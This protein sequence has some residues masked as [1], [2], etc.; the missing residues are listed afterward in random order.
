MTRA[1]N[2]LA[3][4]VSTDPLFFAYRITRYQEARRLGD[5]D[6]AQLL[7]CEVAMLSNLRLCHAPRDDKGLTQI[8]TRFKC[9]PHVLAE[10]AFG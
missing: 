6:L 4:R 5:A 1:L 9:K 8:A 10:I 3:R 2:K 7:G